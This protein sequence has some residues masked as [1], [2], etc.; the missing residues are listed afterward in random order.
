MCGNRSKKTAESGAGVSAPANGREIQ[1][2]NNRISQLENAL[3][4]GANAQMPQNGAPVPAP[5]P[6]KAPDPDF[7]KIPPDKL[8]PI[9]DWD[10]IVAQINQREP[11][12]S[13]FLRKSSAFRNQ[14]TLFL[15]V[16]ND[17][18]L[19]L[20]KESNAPTV[21]NEVLKNNYGQTFTIRV[22]SAKNV[23]PEDSENPINKLLQKAKNLN[24]EVEIKK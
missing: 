13:G 14:N 7:K 15:I 20:F 4:N 21:I 16:D 3:R 24:M 17:F 2:L 12:I 22:K 11:S 9:S 1:A 5:P 23:A 6:A 10:A 18:F 19:K 8:E